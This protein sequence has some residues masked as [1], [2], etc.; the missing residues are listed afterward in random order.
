MA[1]EK[2]AQRGRAHTL[3]WIL[4]L[5]IGL[6]F[7]LMAA[8]GPLAAAG[9]YI[10]ALRPR[11]QPWP[12][13]PAKPVIGAA[14]FIATLAYLVYRTGHMA[15]FYRGTVAATATF[16]NLVEGR[17]SRIGQD[18]DP[19]PPAPSEIPGAPPH[20]PVDAPENRRPPENPPVEPVSP[21]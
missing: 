21:L 4:F 11:W 10:E 7:G 5:V 18:V 1:T 15:G 12:P 6:P 17:G 14:A 16:R 8:L 9:I 19:P 2:T 13:D 3:P 20:A